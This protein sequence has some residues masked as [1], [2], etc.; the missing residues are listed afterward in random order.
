MIE[1]FAARLLDETRHEIDRADTKA[2]ILLAGASVAA[3]ALVAGLLGGDIDPS[4]A[5][6]AVQLV[7]AIAAALIVIGV[8]LLGAAVF[9]RV[10]RGTPGRARYFM[11]HAQ[12]RSV[13]DLREAVVR[14]AADAE[15]RHLEQLLDLSRIVRR[16]YRF[17]RWGEVLVAT[18]LLASAAAGLLHAVLQS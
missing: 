3:G 11:D 1:N 12:Y 8:A 2:S 7:G 16:K 18:G 13:G 15:G 17:T 14:E 9:P 4:N 6:A 10:Q 5:R